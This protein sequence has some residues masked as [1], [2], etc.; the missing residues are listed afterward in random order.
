MSSLESRNPVRQPAAVSELGRRVKQRRDELGL[1]LR[2]CA[3]GH[4]FSYGWLGKLESGIRNPT[5]ASLL[6]VAEALDTSLASL[7]E[8]LSYTPAE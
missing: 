2:A 3:E 8:G 4:D 6:D 1:T 5:L 7:V